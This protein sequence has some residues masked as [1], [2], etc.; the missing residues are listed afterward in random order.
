MNKKAISPLIA[1]VLIVGFTILLAVLV[2]GFI[3]DITKTR[4]C[5]EGCKIEANTGCM[6]LKNFD[7]TGVNGTL[8][9]NIS[10]TNRNTVDASY[11]IGVYD[12]NGASLEVKQGT[13]SSFN[14]TVVEFTGL[15]GDPVS[16]KF[17]PTVE[18]AYTQ[19]DIDK[20]CNCAVTCGE[21]IEITF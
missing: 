9:A 18:V 10:I 15:S 12:L 3:E 14:N 21:G 5:D 4:M 7:I 16:A 19:E 8:L 1:T 2:I 6:N 20:E 17:I 11:A 13:L